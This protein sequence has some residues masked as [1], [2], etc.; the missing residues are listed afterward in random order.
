MVVG[1]DLLIT[2]T[3]PYSTRDCS[4]AQLGCSPSR[5]KPP[6]I[7]A[8]VEEEKEGSVSVF[9]KCTGGINSRLLVLDRNSLA[10][11]EGSPP[12][13]PEVVLPEDLFVS[14]ALA[15]G[16]EINQVF[17]IFRETATGKD[18]KKLLTF[19]AL[20]AA[21][22]FLITVAVFVMLH[23]V[24]VLYERHED[25]VDTFAQKARIEIHKRYAV[26]DAKLLQK[27]PKAPFKGKKEQ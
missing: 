26:L 18:L 19:I 13:F 6:Y 23:T 9:L 11:K 8:N 17:A 27:L 24:P 5:S 4:H 12:K 25:H 14:I 20:K 3:S 15:F 21:I 7:A 16:H 10:T 2:T 1:V 22:S